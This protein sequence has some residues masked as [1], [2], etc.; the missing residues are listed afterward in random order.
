MVVFFVQPHK[1][2]LSLYIFRQN[3]NMGA[4]ST[5]QSAKSC[6]PDTVAALELP[7]T[8][9]AIHYTRSEEHTSELQSLMRLSYDVFCVNKKN[10]LHKNNNEIVI[11]R[12]DKQSTKHQA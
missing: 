7:V 8:G 10:K 2:R 4:A 6:V 9:V 1:N 3:I 11:L 5:V 12:Y